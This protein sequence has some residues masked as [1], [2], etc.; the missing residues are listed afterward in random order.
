MPLLPPS[1]LFSEAFILP[2]TSKQQSNLF[3][4]L[5][6]YT[7]SVFSQVRCALVLD[8]IE[9]DCFVSRVYCWFMEKLTELRVLPRKGV[10]CV[11][12]RFVHYALIPWFSG[13]VV[14]W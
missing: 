2:F 3:S 4:I 11:W 6:S 5:T 12:L 7:G 1:S 14:R 13:D 10:W 8:D 9:R